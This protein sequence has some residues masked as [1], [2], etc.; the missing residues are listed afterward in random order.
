M[1]RAAIISAILSNP[2]E[3]QRMFN[4]IVSD[5]CEIIR[6]RMGIPFDKSNVALI[7]LTVVAELD[8]INAFTGKLGKINGANVKASV[9]PETID[10]DL[11]I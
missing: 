3:S 1:K 4:D 8:I 7:S 10:I 11:D 2:S 9:A 6:G 5:Y